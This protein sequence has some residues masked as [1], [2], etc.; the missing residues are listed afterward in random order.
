MKSIL[1]PL[2]LFTI[3]L[4]VAALEPATFELEKCS[5]KHYQGL[6]E[7][8]RALGA[9]KGFHDDDLN[10]GWYSLH[11]LAPRVVI[12]TLGRI[13]EK[14]PVAGEHTTYKYRFELR[15]EANVHKLFEHL[16]GFRVMNP[17]M[18][19]F[20]RVYENKVPKAL[21]VEVTASYETH[22]LLAYVARQANG[23]EVREYK[24][25]KHEALKALEYAKA[26]EKDGLIFIE[27][28]KE[29][30]P[31]Q[32]L[33]SG[34]KASLEQFDSFFAIQ[35]KDYYW[36][37]MEIQSNLGTYLAL[38]HKIHSYQQ[39]GKIKEL[40]V[41]GEVPSHFALYAPAHIVYELKAI[42]TFGDN[43]SQIILAKTARC[44]KALVEEIER[45]AALG[46]I[47]YKIMDKDIST[48]QYPYQVSA[49]NKDVLM[50]LSEV[51]MTGYVKKEMVLTFS[52]K[53]MPFAV[54]MLKHYIEQG[55][56]DH[57][58]NRAIGQYTLKFR[59]AGYVASRLRM[60]KKIH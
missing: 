47:Y 24:L 39:Q 53:Q 30:L 25:E 48:D 36:Q 57:N 42:A 56:V 27:V 44:H 33:V 19:R 49:I 32:L 6:L 20:G 23:Y 10:D 46:E 1:I 38:K 11:V 3:I 31:W 15:R 41:T 43:K 52:K 17:N 59:G 40:V 34:P 37:F 13:Y 29:R 4:P 26:L 54:E 18:A 60:I 51:S 8:L 14:E 45:L 35:E 58:Y 12:D 50:W 16:V 2:V 21:V 7:P 22:Q 5:L 28:N 55:S 9:V